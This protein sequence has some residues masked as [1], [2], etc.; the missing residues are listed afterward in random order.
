MDRAFCDA[1][2]QR[3]LR[4]RNQHE[5]SVIIKTRY[6]DETYSARLMAFEGVVTGKCRGSL[7][8]VEGWMGASHLP[9]STSPCGT[10]R[11]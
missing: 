8:Y 2:N 9:M 10:Y 5:F 3:P 1:Q 6:H 11:G 4:I 7:R